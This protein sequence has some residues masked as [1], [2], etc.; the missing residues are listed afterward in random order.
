MKKDTLTNAIIKENLDPFELNLTQLLSEVKDSQICPYL[1]IIK[2][3]T[4]KYVKLTI[5]PIQYQKIIKLTLKGVNILYKDIE[6]LSKRLQKYNIIHT[7]GLVS[8]SKNV[9][10]ECYLDL[11]KIDIKY[12]ELEKSLEKIKSIF[13]DIKIE[14]LSLNQK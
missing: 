5:Y 11:R 12:N 6:I 4:E 7:T 13:K 14:E 10:Y 3:N 9:I 2:S 8:K 1:L